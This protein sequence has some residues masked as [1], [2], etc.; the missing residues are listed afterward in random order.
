MHRPIDEFGLL[1]DRLAKD[2]VGEI[3]LSDSPEKVIKKWRNM[4]RVS[5]KSLAERLG[6]TSSVVSDYE[7]GR[8]KSPGIFVIK[9]YVNAIL[10]I[11][12]GSGGKV[13]RGFAK[14]SSVAPISNAIIDM[15]EFSSGVGVEDF[16]SIVGASMI[17]KQGGKGQVYGYTVI[18]SIKAITEFSFQEMVRLYGSTSQ[19]GL[20]FTKVSTGRTPMV[21]IKLTS[22]HPGLVVLHGLSDVDEIAKRIAEVENIP[23]AVSRLENVEDIVER[24]RGID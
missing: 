23:L 3:V 11:D 8:R 4:F 20:I 10:D 16:C 22:L 13:I 17:T 2:I 14:G 6:I 7:S 19:R 9:K 21:A 1:R 18:D 24:L 5:Q 12:E 15:R